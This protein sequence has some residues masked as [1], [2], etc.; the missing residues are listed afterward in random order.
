M[1]AEP[2]RDV[3][4]RQGAESALHENEECFRLLVECVTDY[5]ILMLDPQGRVV[6][7]NAGAKR[8]K[9]YRPEEILGQH[10]SCF[11]PPEERERGWPDYELQQAASKGRYEDEGWRVRKDASRF[12]A[13]VVITAI[14][15]QT[16]GIRGFAKI[17]RDMSERKETEQALARKAREVAQSQ[18][19]LARQTQ[20]LRS[21]LDSMAE[22]VVVADKNGKFLHWNPAA[23]RIIGL[24]A[25]DVPTTEWSEVYGV[26]LPDGSTPCPAEELPLVKAIR[27]ENVDGAELV[28]R[29]PHLPHPLWIKA[30]GRPLISNNGE[31]LGGVVAFFDDTARKRAD[32]EI[33]Q[34]NQELEQR[35]RE[36]TAELAEA[37]TELVQ[38]N[39][40]NET[41][42][43][44]VSHDLRSPLVNLQ[45][46]SKELGLVCGDIR[47]ILA[48]GDL[49]VPVQK[50]GLDL[51]DGDMAQAIQFIQTA[52]MRLSNI[53]DAL[54]RLSRAGRVE[55][56]WQQVDMNTTVGRIVDS[57]N[58]TIAERGARVVVRDLPSAWGDA[59]VLEQIFANLIGNALNY[60]DPQ[61]PGV[62][63]I[64]CQNSAATPDSA[65][66]GVHR[67]Y[68][69]KDNGLGIPDSYQHKI[70]QAFQRLHP[71]A[72]PGE[73]MGLAIVRRFVERLGGKI[74]LDS[75][76]GTGTT[77][78]VAL[79]AEPSH[80]GSPVDS[81]DRK[82]L[83]ATKITRRKAYVPRTTAHFDGGRR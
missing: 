75:T 34:L 45:G 31:R 72:A 50:R 18:E 53:I 59:T 30:T 20:V 2:N 16:G 41:F 51:M 76:V 37:N 39:Q 32:A 52:V 79:P 25:A 27:G 65:T 60:L 74:W 14:R 29:N 61:R 33:G 54:L 43:Y 35:V 26:F 40:E 47:S 64:G 21:I 77:F 73:G 82:T 62:I 68:W 56:Q 48:N 49:P 9:G 13:N 81:S 1:K 57:M 36:R 28:I 17:T 80:N 8:L 11:Y 58:A 70:F 10:F 44:S 4:E 19:D 3:I 83:P 78:F 6:S 66:A 67:I 12:W 7:W 15:D 46:F 63:E 71:E 23:E 69:V 22:G 42:V 5:A 24:G 55:F 38:K